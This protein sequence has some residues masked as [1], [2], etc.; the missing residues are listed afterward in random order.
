M[1]MEFTDNG[2]QVARDVPDIS[3]DELAEWMEIKTK[4]EALKTAIEKSFKLRWGSGNRLDLESG[5][6]ITNAYLLFWPD[7][8]ARIVQRLNEEKDK[9]KANE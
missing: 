4:L 5:D 9:E 8:Y 6:L 7:E 3:K 2:I 1:S